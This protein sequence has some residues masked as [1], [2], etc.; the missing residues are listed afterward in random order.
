MKIRKYTSKHMCVCMYVCIY[1]YIWNVYSSCLRPL[2]VYL[3]LPSRGF[4][5]LGRTAVV[6]DHAAEP[7]HLA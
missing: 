4:V 6:L 2:Y 3:N 7:Q 1:I 5:M